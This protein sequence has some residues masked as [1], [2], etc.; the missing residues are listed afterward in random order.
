[1]TDQWKVVLIKT[2]E[3]KEPIYYRIANIE[4]LEVED[5]PAYRIIDE[6]INRKRNIVNLKC[7]N[8]KIYTLDCDGY[9]G[10]NGII[11]IDEFDNE[12]PSI[13]E[14]WTRDPDGNLLYERFD[15]NKN[16]FSPSSYKISTDKKI[17]WTCENEHTI[18]C[19]YPT[20]YSIGRYC[21]FC[22]A[23]ERGETI[24]LKTWAYITD[25]LEILEMYNKSNKNTVSA[26]KISYKSRKEVY[27]ER[28][29][30]EITEYLHKVTSEKIIPRFRTVVNLTKYK[31]DI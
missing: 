30:E 25:N 11:V 7:E 1:M 26:D 24:S 17:S 4:T 9:K 29:E 20:F 16:G 2:I 31:K 28:N 5:I 3:Y 21:P 15:T 12:I 8:N 27:F 19:G 13:F 22:I 10:T 6:I 18:R 23:E 14:S